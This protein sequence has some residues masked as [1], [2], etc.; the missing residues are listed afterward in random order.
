MVG[1]VGMWLWPISSTE[2]DKK[3]CVTV[4]Q[5]CSDSEFNYDDERSLVHYSPPLMSGQTLKSGHSQLGQYAVMGSLNGGT[6]SLSGHL[7][8]QLVLSY[9]THR[10]VILLIS[11]V[12]MGCNACPRCGHLCLGQV[13]LWIVSANAHRHLGATDH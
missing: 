4:R 2:G 12:Q 13:L 5:I 9:T 1:M 8:G 3:V 11:L 6:H 10:V 7:A